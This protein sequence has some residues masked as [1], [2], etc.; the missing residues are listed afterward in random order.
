[1]LF[2]HHIIFMV[3]LFG[4]GMV[5]LFGERRQ[6][7]FVCVLLESS[8]VRGCIT[9]KNFIPDEILQKFIVLIRHHYVNSNG[10]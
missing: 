2:F 5:L 8:S 10:N 9:I 3:L 1:M 7:F 4:E 6:S